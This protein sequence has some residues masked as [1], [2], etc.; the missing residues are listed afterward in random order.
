MLK[1]QP[2]DLNQTW[3]VG[4]KWWRFANAPKNFGAVPLKF[5][6]PKHENLDYFI[7]DVCI[8]HRI[9]PERNV[10]STNQN[11]IVYLQRVP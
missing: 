8:R 1:D 2:W 11:A 6:A 10:A 4:R 5:D 3:P 7:R 9:S